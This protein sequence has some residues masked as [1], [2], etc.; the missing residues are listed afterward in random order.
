MGISKIKYYL[1]VTANPLSNRVAAISLFKIINRLDIL[2][3]EIKIFLPGFHVSDDNERDTEAE[4]NNRI[5]EIEKYNKAIENEDYHGKDPIFHTYIDSHG[6]IYFNDVDFTRFMSDM[7]EA[8]P[9]F[10]YCGE[11][12]LVVLPTQKGEIIYEQVKSYTLDSLSNDEA[13]NKDEVEKFILSVIKL[14]R[15]DEDKDSLDLLPKIDNLYSNSFSNNSIEDNSTKVIIRL[16]NR[17][18]EFM[19]WKE[20][21][22]IFFVSYSTKDEFDAYAFKALLEKHNKNVWMAPDGIPAGLD[23]ACVIP[24]ALR[25]T[26]RFV[27]L[28]SHNSANSEW[29]RKEIGK[30]VTNKKRLDGIFL[31]GFSYKDVKQYD[32]LDFLLE[33]VQLKYNLKDMFG[34]N[35]I[36][37]HFFE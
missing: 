2:S 28:L 31:D 14:I 24:A 5:N 27:V 19:K 22:E 37:R 26:T 25:I 11:T 29:V 7:E 30:A 6:D 13:K 9:T 1:L 34:N 32:H 18:L 36:L 3:R 10:E 21:D 33:N 16:D 4:V 15:K 8:C 12:Q 35:S 23:Y 20:H 17:L